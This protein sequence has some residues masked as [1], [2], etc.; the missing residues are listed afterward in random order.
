[1]TERDYCRWC[2][3]EVADPRACTCPH[4][5]GISHCRRAAAAPAGCRRGCPRGECYCSEPCYGDQA[6]TGICPGCGGYEECYCGED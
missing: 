2:A 1:M 6:Y 5:C 3:D 4:D